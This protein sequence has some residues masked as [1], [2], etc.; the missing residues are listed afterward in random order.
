MPFGRSAARRLEGSFWTILIR[1]IFAGWLLALMVWLL[2]GAETS[3]PM[4]VIILTFL[5]GLGGFAHIVAGSTEIFYLLTTGA[6]SWGRGMG[7]WL[8]PTLIGNII[9]GVSLVAALNHAQV[10]SG[11]GEDDETEP[12]TGSSAHEQ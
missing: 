9:G 1:A 10:T 6:A 4:I 8:V 12:D 2:P 3:R 5:V 11:G 7:G